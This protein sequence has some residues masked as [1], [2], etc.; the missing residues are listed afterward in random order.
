MLYVTQLL[1]LILIDNFCCR[2]QSFLF[3]SAL[4]Q[5]FFL[6]IR[7]LYI[8]FRGH[9]IGFWCLDFDMPRTISVQV[10]DET[11]ME[12]KKM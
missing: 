2:F 8:T 3:F 12:V 6:S 5:H 11:L 4:G 10:E 7:I 1:T 9:K